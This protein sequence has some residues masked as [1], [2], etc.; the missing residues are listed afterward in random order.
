MAEP[1]QSSYLERPMRVWAARMWHQFQ[2]ILRQHRGES[3]RRRE[4]DVREFF[5]ALLPGRLA[6]GTGEIISV[7]GQT[8][9]QIDLIV[10]DRLYTPLFDPSP[11][12]I[13]VPVEGVY[14]VIEVSSQLD[15]AK[16]RGDVEKIRAV[17]GMPKAAYR[18]QQEGEVVTSSYLWGRQQI[19]YFPVVGFCF[20]YESVDLTTLWTALLDIDDAEDRGNSVDMIC[21]LSRG[22]IANGR[23]GTGGR[24][25]G[26]SAVP[27]LDTVRFS[28]APP[29][30]PE[31][32]EAL[33]LFYLLAGD[34]LASGF[35]RPIATTRYSV[36]GV[37]EPGSRLD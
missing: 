3:G 37:P 18:E 23:A 19:G 20:A 22:C 34:V 33:M 16:L 29:G 11:S 5:E 1:E 9:P 25:I 36:I 27:A 24:V 21:S 13:V 7:D 17:K 4:D 32:G 31:T 2:E 12:S 35:T 26:A 8:S 28:F 14:G 6:V 30:G 15:V 10:Y